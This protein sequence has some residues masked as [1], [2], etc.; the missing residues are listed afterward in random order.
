[1]FGVFQ[2]CV[3]CSGRNREVSAVFHRPGVLFGNF[4]RHRLKLVLMASDNLEPKFGNLD[5]K[6]GTVETGPNFLPR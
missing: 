3:V 1:M 4:P 6:F 5:R 2:R